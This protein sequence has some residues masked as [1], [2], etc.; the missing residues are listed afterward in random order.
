[1]NIVWAPEALDRIEDFAQ[2]MAQ[3]DEQLAAQWID[4]LFERVEVLSH[5]PRSGRLV[6]EA[7]REDLREII[8]KN[9]RIIYRLQA[10][11][12]EVLTLF[13]SRQEVDGDQF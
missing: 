4:D 1:M 7:N 13:H 2:S 11:T 5:L 9:Y 12:I 3:H 10:G 8:W 6:P